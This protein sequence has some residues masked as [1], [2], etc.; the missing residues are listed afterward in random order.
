MTRVLHSEVVPRHMDVVVVG[1]LAY[2]S[3]QTPA[4]KGER[5]LGGSATYAGLASSACDAS[6]GVVGVVGNDFR[7]EDR[8]LLAES[9]LDLAGLVT[10]EG[11]TFHWEGEY[12]GAMGEAST[13]NTELNVFEAFDPEVPAA[14]V[15]PKVL[16]CANL[17]PALQAKVLDQCS[18]T[19]LR[20]LDSMNLWIDIARPLLDDVLQRVDVVVL[21]DGEVRMLADDANLVRAAQWLH[22]QLQPGAILIVKRGEHGVLALHPSGLLHVPSVPSPGLVDPTGCGDS[23]AGTLAA[24]LSKGEGPVGREELRTGLEHAAVVASYTL[25]GLGVTGLV[26]MDRQDREARLQVLRAL[27]H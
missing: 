18:P 1:S 4:A 16:F 17:H 19:R 23:F 5:L 20:M 7:P 21:N 3:I 2:D 25:Q 22:G 15:S 9:G 26:A 11:N 14:W 12:S 24:H 6:C 10:A 13:L 27:T 8:D